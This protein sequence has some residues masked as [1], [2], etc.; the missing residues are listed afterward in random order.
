MK[1]VFFLIMMALLFIP[2]CPPPNEGPN[3]TME[4]NANLADLKYSAGT[5][6]PEFSAS[7]KEYTLTVASDISQV[8]ITPIA[9]NTEATLS[10]QNQA[11]N[12]GEKTVITLK[13]AGET[14]DVKIEV[15]SANKANTETYTLHIQRAAVTLLSG[16]LIYEGTV[17][18]P[19]EATPV[20]LNREFESDI[21]N[22]QAAS[23]DE[24]STTVTFVPTAVDPQATL[25]VKGPGETNEQS[26][27]SGK[28]VVVSG[29]KIN[30][31]T[32]TLEVTGRNGLQTSIYTFVL[33]RGLNR[34][35]SLL[36]LDI[37][38]GT[39]IPS[40]SPSIT[41]YTMHLPYTIDTL[42]VTP[43]AQAYTAEVQVNTQLITPDE[44]SYTR[45]LIIGATSIAVSV[46]AEDPGTN[47]V[48]TITVNRAGR[49]T[50][51]DL[52]LSSGVLEPSFLANQKNYSATVPFE[53][54]TVML[55]PFV[56]NND[57][58][59]TVNGFRTESGQPTPPINLGFEENIINVVVSD[60]YGI[61]TDTYSVS[62]IREKNNNAA[63]ESL[64]VVSA[65][66]LSPA[67]D[68][69]SEGPYEVNVAHEVTE[70]TIKVKAEVVY[71]T[72]EIDGD[73]PD[74]EGEILV[75]LSVGQNSFFIQVTAQDEVTD[76]KYR[77]IINR[78]DA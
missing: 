2:G 75:D 43:A 14:T 62:L 33:T 67:F 64:E 73:N 32:V 66:E 40:F 1:R 39:L 12:S 47:K 54:N 18:L 10:I 20:A 30:E 65:G 44:P 4:K 68:P 59:I 55:T 72:V 41:S 63:L 46:Q 5:L 28:A 60:S 23:L 57:L 50:L 17:T 22:Y 9:A 53:T 24:N 25:V 7:Q 8:S 70:I 27:E 38:S 11:V 76:K 34:N 37:S 3:E 56:D 16:L 61:N 15:T 69:E 77:L 6:S 49:L 29:L 74:P 58:I 52:Q 13:A 42:T 45:N 36:I 26:V 19:A 48:Y 51:S 31:N 78:A 21:F 35:A 71:S